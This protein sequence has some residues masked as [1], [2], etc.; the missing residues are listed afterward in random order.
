MWRVAVDAEW[1]HEQRARDY[2]DRHDFLRARWTAARRIDAVYGH[3]G[4]VVSGYE[5]PTIYGG[6]IGNFLVADPGASA[7][8]EQ[9]LLS[10]FHPGAPAFFGD[11]GNYFEQN[12][13][14]FGLALA[15][16]ALP[17]LDGG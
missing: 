12:W 9:I 17:N 11:S 10:S 15:G 13:V 2:L 6:D 14:W 3:D 16:G 8:I 1:N 7:Q 5:D 4:T